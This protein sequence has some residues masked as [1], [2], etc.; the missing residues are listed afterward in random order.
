MKRKLYVSLSAL[1]GALMITAGVARVGENTEPVVVE[2]DKPVV[3]TEAVPEESTATIEPETEAPLVAVIELEPEDWYGEDRTLTEYEWGIMAQTI[4]AEARG[5]S[6]EVQYY[7]ACVILNRV[8]SELFPNSVAGVIFQT[9]PIQFCGAWDTQKY[10]V[11]DSVWEAIQ[12]ALIYNDLPEDVFY[13]TSEGY[14]PNTEPWKKEGAM[15]FS[16]QK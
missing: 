11:S 16:R 12:E 4:M 5:E 10:E 7:I 13:F 1:A 6:H 9:E 8:D 2:L 14:L 3:M 15:W